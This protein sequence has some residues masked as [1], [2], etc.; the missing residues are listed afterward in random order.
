M[1]G[2]NSVVNI[3]VETLG[4]S[5]AFRIADGGVAIEQTTTEMASAEPASPSPPS[6]A[7]PRNGKGRCRPR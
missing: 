6:L 3:R 5:I 2:S 7:E 4:V 1:M